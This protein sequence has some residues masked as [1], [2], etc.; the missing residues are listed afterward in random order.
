MGLLLLGIGVVPMAILA[1]AWTALSVASK[2]WGAFVALL[3]LLF[4]TLGLV[5]TF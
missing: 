1:A 5:C 4:L 3:I 2:W